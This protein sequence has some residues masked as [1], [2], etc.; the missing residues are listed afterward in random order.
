MIHPIYFLLSILALSFRNWIMALNC[1][2]LKL[3]FWLQVEEVWDGALCPDEW[4]SCNIISLQEQFCAEVSLVKF[5][6]PHGTFWILGI[7]DTTTNFVFFAGFHVPQ[8]HGLSLQNSD[9]L[10]HI[11]FVIYEIEEYVHLDA[12][13]NSDL[14]VI[15]RY[16]RL[17]FLVCHATSILQ[18]YLILV[19]WHL[20]K[21]HIF[22]FF[23]S[24]IL[25]TSTL[26]LE[27]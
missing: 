2:L 8:R 27:M 6:F 25:L 11:I 4:W 21:I 19:L 17:C 14:K 12:C 18:F 16:K 1:Y 24:V 10:S 3:I 23:F 7:I 9:N 5:F 15:I 22:V 26:Q 20:L 13:Y